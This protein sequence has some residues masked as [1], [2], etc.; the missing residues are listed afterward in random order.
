[1]NVPI[2]H[3]GIERTDNWGEGDLADRRII[4]WSLAFTLKGYLYGPTYATGLIKFV[5]VPLYV[6]SPDVAM[7]DAT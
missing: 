4:V 1:M 3:A 2:V 7:A 5:D 6:P